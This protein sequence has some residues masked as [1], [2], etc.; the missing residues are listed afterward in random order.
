MRD[1][2]SPTIFAQAPDVE[3]LQ[4]IAVN[5]FRRNKL[6]RGMR[7][8]FVCDGET[9]MML[10]LLGSPVTWLTTSLQRNLMNG[11]PPAPSLTTGQTSLAVK[12]HWG[13]LKPMELF[14]ELIY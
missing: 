5:H 7:V 11:L 13:V 4:S 6:W 12:A 9:R 10:Q 1:K 8:V 14:F 3:R 2:P